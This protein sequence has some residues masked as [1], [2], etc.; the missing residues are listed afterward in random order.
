MTISPGSRL[1]SFEVVSSLGA[2]GMGQVY[3]ARD[4]K[5]GREV[6]LKVLPPSFLLEADRVARFQREAQLLAALNHPHIAAIHGLEQHEGA[7]LLVLELVDG[8]TL[9][10]RLAAARGT[11]LGLNDTLAIAR[12]IADALEAAHERGIIHRDLKPANIALTADGRVKVLDFG[13]AKFQAGGAG[14]AGGSRPEGLT[15]SPTLTV[16]AT[17]AGVILGTAAYMAP[18]QAKGRDADKRADVWAFGCVL[19][20]MLTGRRAFDGED[21]TDTIAAVVRGDPDWTAIPAE[22]PDQIRLLVRRCLEKDRRARIGDVSV[23]R[24][25]LNETIAP[26]PVR[27]APVPPASASTGRRL[28]LVAAASLALGASVTAGT[29]WA[30]STPPASPAPVR[31]VLVPA[32]QHALTM[33]G[34]DRDLAIAPD[35]SFVV[36]RSFVGADASQLV[37]R[38]F[39]EFESRALSTAGVNPRS[40]FV[41]PN[42]AWVGYFAAGALRKL[43]ADGGPSVTIGALASGPRGASWGDNDIIVFAT[44]DVTSG[45]FSVAGGGGD[46]KPLTTPNREKGEGDHIFPSVLPGSRAVLFT[47]QPPAGS[48]SVND[49]R[50]AVLDVESGD[51]KVLIQ[52]ASHPQYVDTGHILYAT[53]DGTLRAVRF[54]SD[55]L[56]LIGD[57]VPVLDDVRGF[58]SGAAQ[59][60]VAAAGT[61]AYVPG[62]GTSG[63][64]DRPLVWVNRQGQREVIKG[65]GRPYNNP[66]L[67]PDG[68][69]VAVEITD[70]ADDIWI[71]DTVRATLSRQTVET[72]EDET[73][74]WS[75]DGRWVAYSSSRNATE[76]F[77]FRQRADGGGAEESLWKG[78]EHVHVEDWTPDGKALIVSLSTTAGSSQDLYLLPVE[79]DRTLKPLLQ[80]QFGER[81]ARLSPDGRWMAYCSNETGRDE[82]YV[83]PFPSL[84]GRFPISTEGGCQPVWSR[85]GS[86]LFF[87]G[88]IKEARVVLAVPVSIGATF[89]A[90]APQKLFD[91]PFYNKGGGHQGFDVAADGRFIFVAGEAAEA[92]AGMAL[93]I[94]LVFNWFEELKAKAGVR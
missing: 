35:G 62:G 45:L 26:P 58:V 53:S 92:Q 76:R 60:S 69:Q 48:G 80:S 75:P 89:S 1:G 23:A 94:H 37:I 16:H 5:L 71:L 50:V 67:S 43:P 66:R 44:S 78:V 49:F 91:D 6:A 18:E 9:A 82:V 54:D 83:R 84:E 61:L 21:L 47:M 81:A 36:Y 10:D 40:P 72:L 85:K 79:G 27:P 31:M 59:F 28:A 42:N 77:V 70:D 25:L 65:P 64:I 88:A 7:P 74:A 11:G 12:Q 39:N 13:L 33:Q 93:P 32:P 22:V 20:E 56:A 52:G 57:P 34:S 73:N 90:G 87:R 55:R 63:T 68:R 17:Q 41:S 30:L 14:E 29:W 19:Y 38:R 86:E 15:H 8:E 3:R 2:G 51:V 46:P 4:T 24:F